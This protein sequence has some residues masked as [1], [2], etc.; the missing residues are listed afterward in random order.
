MRPQGR[1]NG[2]ILIYVT[3][4]FFISNLDIHNNWSC[5]NLFYLYFNT[6][7]I[8]VDDHMLFFDHYIVFLV[9]Y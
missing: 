3:D 2:I 1:F 7:L 8:L 9:I 6:F 5:I 4:E